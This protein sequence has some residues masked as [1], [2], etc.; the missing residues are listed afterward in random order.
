LTRGILKRK[1]H[2]RDQDCRHRRKRNANLL[3]SRADAGLRRSEGNL[4]CIGDLLV[5]QVVEECETQCLA[6]RMR[7]TANRES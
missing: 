3:D 2:D 5:R 7:K 1:P 4:E 6:L